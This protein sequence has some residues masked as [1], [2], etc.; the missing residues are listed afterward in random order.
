MQEHAELIVAY[1]NE[2]E[3]ART[4]EIAEKLGLSPDRTRVIL[5]NMPE[6]EA[7]GG[8]RNRTY[9]LKSNR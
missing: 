5:A 7:L 1:L 3:E 2:V 4:A 6:L 9:R 8:N